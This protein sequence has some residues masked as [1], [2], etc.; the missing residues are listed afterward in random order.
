MPASERKA[1]IDSAEAAIQRMRPWARG[2]TQAPHKPLLL[3][4]ALRRVAESRPRLVA[5]PEVEPELRDLIGRFS[6]VKSPPNAGYPFWR[7]QADGLWEI[8]GA[9]T[10]PTRA[11]NSDPPLR[12]LRDRPARGGF[13]RQL[14][15]ALRAEPAEVQRVATLIANRFFRPEDDVLRVVG[16]ASRRSSR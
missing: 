9:D 3:L 5:F 15:S 4:V 12:E 1:S 7:L 14:D 11:S 2:G 8:E 6:D 16:L 10:F 13:P